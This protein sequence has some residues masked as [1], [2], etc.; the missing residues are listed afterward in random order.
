MPDGIDTSESGG[1]ARTYDVFIS[2]AHRDEAEF[3]HAAALAQALEKAGHSVWY[4]KELM[5]DAG[6][7]WH[8]AITAKMDAS[9]VIVALW[10]KVALSRPMCDF[11]G[12]RAAEKPEMLIP[13]ELS[14][15]AKEDF[16][17]ELYGLTYRVNRVPYALETAVAQIAAK[18]NDRRKAQAK[19][20]LE[21]QLAPASEAIAKLAAGKVSLPHELSRGAGFLAGRDREETL[22]VDAWASCAAGADPA[23]KTHMLV[24]HAI[25][26]QGKTAL[27]RRLV[28]RLAAADFPH[29]E[30][31]LGWSAYSQGSG[32]NRSTAN[33]E[34][35]I[36]DGLRFMGELGALP[37][38]GVTRARLLAQRLKETRT[39]LL[40]DGIEPLQSLPE[41]NRGRLKDKGLAALLAEL[42]MGHQGLVVITSRQELP[43]VENFTAPKVINRGLGF[44]DVKSGAHLLRHLGCWGS[45]RS[46]EKAVEEAQGHAL[47]VTLLGSYIN[48][49]E[50]GDIARRDHL[51]LAG[52]IDTADEIG[53]PEQTQRFAKRAG[54]IMQGYIAAFEQLKTGSKG[55]GEAEEMLL[56][57]VGLFDR[58]ADGAAVRA[59]LGGEPIAGLTDVMV[60]WSSQKRTQRLNAARTRLRSLKLL[61]AEDAAD[62]DGLDA[63]PVVRAHFAKALQ[64]APAGAFTAAHERLYRHHAAI[65]KDLPDTLDEMQP[66]FHAIGHACAAGLHQEALDDVYFRRVRRGNGDY[67]FKGLGAYEAALG[68]LAPFFDPPWAAPSGNLTAPDRSFALNQASFALRALGRLAEAEASEAAALAMQVKNEQWRFA[69]MG[70]GNLSELRL[71]I[72][73]VAAA[74]ATGEEAIRFADRSGDDSHSMSKRATHADALAQAGRASTALALFE[75]AERRQAQL[76]PG[77]PRLYS[78]SGYRYC[79]LLL[80]RGAAAVVRGRAAYAIKVAQRNGWLLDIGLDT[81]SDGRALALL[82]AHGVLSARAGAG[83]RLDEAVEALRAAAQDPYLASGLLARAAFRRQAYGWIGDPADLKAADTDLR[84]VE[85]I[86]GRGGMKLF[87]TD[88]RLESARLALAQIQAA[89]PEALVPLDPPLAPRP[90]PQSDDV[91]PKSDGTAK[92]AGFWTRLLSGGKKP[93]P[94]TETVT[95][96]PNPRPPPLTLDE[97]RHLADAEAHA[98]AAHALIAETGYHRRDGEMADLRARLDALNARRNG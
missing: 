2:Y 44:L 4:D 74:V 77:L 37:K 36:I 97:Q 63:H 32:E 76:Q 34:Q 48:A 55:G 29:A 52:I 41:V 78:I 43:E 50:G 96:K 68:A 23:K 19:A 7:D 6:T 11:E 8:A 35:F 88:W 10:S 79:D 95:A 3:G 93:V 86:A 30:K 69:S 15:I 62:L 57:I 84:E 82:A 27:L 5:N 72:G 65:P 75:D 92:P 17:E 1:D 58:P 73:K 60:G 81:L 71:A 20:A 21:H 67:T 9:L 83:P 53:A 39:L 89:P 40:L 70:A 31:V 18:V 13:F 42:A 45:T 90:A 14:A 38:D 85:D 26:G 51:G 22:L 64:A 49:V 33:A 16:S 47:S 94:V 98:A 80:E 66:L 59:L 61:A 56:S 28:D 87:L 24:L 12:K 54:A 25:G 46:M 91:R